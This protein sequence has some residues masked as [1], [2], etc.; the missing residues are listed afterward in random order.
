MT[1]TTAALSH[2]F[3]EAQVHVSEDASD[4]IPT[5]A[6]KEIVTAYPLT[7]KWDKTSS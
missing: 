4:L 5:N 2:D 1:V 6:G 3:E 7:D